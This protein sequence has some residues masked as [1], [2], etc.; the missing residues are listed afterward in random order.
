MAILSSLTRSLAIGARPLPFK[1]TLQAPGIYNS[2]LFYTSSR[3]LFRQQVKKPFIPSPEQLKVVQLCAEQNVVVSARPGSG[4]TATAEA[5]VAAYPH[6][7]TGAFVY[8]KLLQL[9]TDR[10]FK[11]YPNAKAFTMH[12]MARLLSG[13][14]VPNDVTLL[15]QIKA[16][17]NSNMLPPGHF[18]PFDIIVLDEFQD[19]S[20][21]LYWLILCF[22]R[23]IYK[24]RGADQ[25]YLTL[26]SDLLGHT[27]PSP[28]VNLP[29][30]ESFRLSNETVQFINQAFLGGDSYITSSKTG[31]KPI[32]LRCNP[33]RSYGLAKKLLTLIDQYG[34]ENT[35]IIAPA[36]RGNGALIKLVN[37]LAEEHHVPIAEPI[38]DDG[39]LDERVIDGK[40]CIST[41]HQFKGRERDLIILLG[42]DSSFFEYIGRDL[43]DNTCPNQV[44]VAL[45]RAVKQLVLVH[46]DRK[47][48]M[49]FV[50]VDALYK[51]A[52]VINMT[53][54]KGKISLPDKPGRPIQLGLVLPKKVR[55]SDIAR[56]VRG[57]RLDEIVRRD[58]SI[59]EISPQ[60]DLIKIPN[61]V[62][63][64]PKRGF[65][66]AVG[67]VNGLVVE[68][69]YQHAITG[70]VAILN[71]NNDDTD[72]NI[73]VNPEAQIP[74]L[75]R[76]AC[77]YQ[78]DF[79]GYRP[80]Q[81]QM[82]EHAF[83]W[84]EPKKLELARGRLQRELGDSAAN[85]H[86]EVAVQQSFDVDNERT[87]L[88][89]RADV[90]SMPITV[91]GGDTKSIESV[92]EIKFV[93]QLSN[94]HIVQACTYAYLLAVQLGRI[95]RIILFNVRD[96]KKVEITPYDGLE[97]LR[98]MIENILRLKFTALEEIGDE[99]FVEMCA[100]SAQKVSSLD[101]PEK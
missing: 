61:V 52:D 42:I 63:S 67:D 46:D 53:P 82:K 47:E 78:A 3:G 74:W 59:Q 64:D 23:S 98:R 54:N 21:L 19:C 30:S 9:E 75:C 45:T 95:P 44:F 76:Q 7:R 15:K 34:A 100:K 11:K 16:I 62:S 24:Y 80:R 5:I 31:P 41:I 84:I 14:V 28:F 56:H 49:P 17:V 72:Q 8:T 96:G 10:R 60:Q 68:A 38:D 26:A 101:D 43:P 51:T 88:Y 50:S 2:S 55:I 36:I 12:T 94:E 65:Y 25:R 35:A 81:L 6:L 33:Y 86:F 4:K 40:M 57:E 90:V 89:G 73:P 1:P 85:I 58:L 13:V 97:G 22:I 66:E 87:I 91:D 71:S 69:A 70:T 20:E 83:N 32:V 37:I 92:W 77:K 79:S 18:E 48:V 39:P 29:L 99:E 27:N 93:S